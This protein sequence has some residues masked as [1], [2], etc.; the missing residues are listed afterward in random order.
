[1][2]YYKFLQKDGEPAYGTGKWY[3]PKGKR[4]GKWMPFIEDIGLCKRGYHAC[5]QKDLIQW[6]NKELYEVEL[7]GTIIKDDNKVVAQQARLIRRIDSWNDKNARLFVVKCAKRVLPIF[8]KEYPNDKRPRIVIEKAR[9]FALGEISKEE[10]AVARAAAGDAAGAAARDAAWA[11]AWDAARAAAGAAARDAAGDAA[12][13]A[14]WAA[15][16]AA[17]AAAWDAARAAAW[18]AARAAAWDAAW[19]AAGAAG[20]AARA[21]A[22]DAARAA[23]AAAWAAARA[24]RDAARDAERKWQTKT[25]IKML[26]L[27]KQNKLNPTH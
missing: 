5:E 13:D 4:K 8:E 6:T 14:A 24:A 23:G 27:K 22:W 25:L 1:M 19:A 18:D 12:R 15:G 3:L 16:D 26:G 2:K 20:D 10:L 7:K 17:R 11:A 9:L 21:A